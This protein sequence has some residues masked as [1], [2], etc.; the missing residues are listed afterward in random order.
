M[1]WPYGEP[2]CE[3]SSRQKKEGGEGEGQDAN[4]RPW[5]EGFCMKHKGT[6]QYGVWRESK[7]YLLI[8]Q[9]FISSTER[10]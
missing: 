6:R 7:I 9:Y 2:R 3:E 8:F 10:F 5:V 4:G 1:P